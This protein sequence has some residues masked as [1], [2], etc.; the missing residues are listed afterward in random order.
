MRGFNSE[1]Q[2]IFIETKDS[3]I[4]DP[5]TPM[6]LQKQFANKLYLR[7]ALQ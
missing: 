2:F 7:W 3:A 4:Y 6:G 5:K 1:V